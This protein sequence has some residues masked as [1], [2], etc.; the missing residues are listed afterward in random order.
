MTEPIF[1]F[2][3]LKLFCHIVLCPKR[4]LSWNKMSSKIKTDYMAQQIELLIAK[5]DDLN[6]IPGAYTSL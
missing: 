4:K 6:S 1:R 2:V 5:L 3:I